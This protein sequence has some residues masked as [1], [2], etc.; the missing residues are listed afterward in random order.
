MLDIKATTEISAP[1]YAVWS[2]LT[3]FAR[4]SGWN[5]FIRRAYGAAETGKEVRLHVRS[6]FGLPL[7]FRATVLDTDEDHELHWEGHLFADWLARGEHWFTIEPID[8]HHVRFVQRE[9]F[10]GLLPA[11][12]GRLL[13]REAKHGFEQMNHALAERAV[14]SKV[15][16]GR[17]RSTQH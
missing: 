6:S 7:A 1:A 5:P 9:R 4:Y 14:A 15:R 17:P 2:V 3:D 16:P 8:E 10:S 12:A 13:A 11:L